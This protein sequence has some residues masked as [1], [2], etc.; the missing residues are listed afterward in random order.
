MRLTLRRFGFYFLFMAVTVTL[1]QK[2]PPLPTNAFHAG[3][4]LGLIAGWIVLG[5]GFD[6]GY[7]LVR[8]YVLWEQKQLPIDVQPTKQFDVPETN[9][10]TKP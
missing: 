9:K 10:L 6:I 3:Q 5:T 8:R 1:M 7:R 2:W 4:W